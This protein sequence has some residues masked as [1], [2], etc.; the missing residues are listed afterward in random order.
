MEVGEYRAGSLHEYAVA[1][2]EQILCAQSHGGARCKVGIGTIS[3][4][5]S[6]LG[7]T[8][9]LL[10]HFDS[11]QVEVFYSRGCDLN[12]PHQPLIRRGYYSKQALGEF[13]SQIVRSLFPAEHAFTLPAHGPEVPILATS[14]GRL[15]TRRISVHFSQA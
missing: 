1:V 8:V 5:K 12:S 6:G 14:G 2:N 10:V 9:G 4:T 15:Q 3:M 11:K 7:H 13:H